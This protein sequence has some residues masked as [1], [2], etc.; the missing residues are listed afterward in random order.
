MDNA[1][2]P[3]LV[4]AQRSHPLAAEVEFR[5]ANG[6]LSWSDKKGRKGALR[7][8]HISDLR[9]TYDPSRL[10]Q[11]RWVVDLKS[12]EAEALRFTST[13]LISGSFRPRHGAFLAFLSAL[14]TTIRRDAPHA[15]CRFGPSW[16]IYSLRMTLWWLPV[17]GIGLVAYLSF[18]ESALSAGVFFSFM[19]I[20]CGQFAARYAYFNWPRHYQAEAPPMA[21]LPKPTPRDV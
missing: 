5:L 15:I 17:M 3:T 20:Y 2:D 12:K 16:P 9:I 6:F 11:A 10:T 8:T 7:T 13:T 18:T 14:H 19:M 1:T 21:L 4:Y